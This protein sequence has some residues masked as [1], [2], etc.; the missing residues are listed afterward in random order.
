[1]RSQADERA[2]EVGGRNVPVV[3]LVAAPVDEYVLDT[4][5]EKVD[6]AEDVSRSGLKRVLQRLGLGA[7]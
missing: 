2:T 4:V 6:V 1:V 3:D 5:M 7:Q